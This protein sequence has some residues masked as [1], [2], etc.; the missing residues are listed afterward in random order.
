LGRLAGDRPTL[1]TGPG[2]K[3][4]TLRPARPRSIPI[5]ENLACARCIRI[6]RPFSAHLQHHVYCSLPI[7]GITWHCLFQSPQYHPATNPQ[8]RPES[9]RPF[10]FYPPS[11]P[12]C[13]R[14]PRSQI[15]VPYPAR[16]SD[17]TSPVPFTHFSDGSIVSAMQFWG[18]AAKKASLARGSLGTLS[19][20]GQPRVFLAVSLCGSRWDKPTL[21]RWGNTFKY[22]AEINADP[23]TVRRHWLA[24]PRKT[25]TSPTC[26]MIRG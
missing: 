2:W 11:R 21:D 24:M 25:W 17:F 22:A 9:S 12:A 19:S 13:Y 3:P 26:R 1:K 7:S 15:T 8:Y 5:G 14:H 20:C 6:L 10:Q 4:S 18:R 23:A 16:A